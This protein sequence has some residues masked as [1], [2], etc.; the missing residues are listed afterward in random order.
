MEALPSKP[1]LGPCKPPRT[2]TRR[3]LGYSSNAWFHGCLFSGRSLCLRSRC[4]LAHQNSE[5]AQ[6]GIRLILGPELLR[7]CSDKLL[8]FPVLRTAVEQNHLSPIGV[9]LA[10]KIALG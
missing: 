4:R 9:K 3:L 8:E 6:R 5:S 2:S 1:R 10:Q 7:Q